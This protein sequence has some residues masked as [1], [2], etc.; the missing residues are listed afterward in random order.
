MITESPLTK[1]VENAK[2][3][4]WW[5]DET[6]DDLAKLFPSTNDP[7]KFSGTG[8]ELSKIRGAMKRYENQ[9]AEIMEDKEF[10]ESRF[11]LQFV[12]VLSDG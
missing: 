11:R 7:S 1:D 10:Y 2:R 9:E 3:A 4:V 12:E 8:K 6:D 5:D